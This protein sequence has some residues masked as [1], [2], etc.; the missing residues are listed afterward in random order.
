MNSRGTEERALRDEISLLNN[1]IDDLV[2]NDDGQLLSL[3]RD[4][5][6]CLLIL[7]ERCC[8]E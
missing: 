3:Y 4:I 5:T 2:K 6:S 8:S 1:K 7:K